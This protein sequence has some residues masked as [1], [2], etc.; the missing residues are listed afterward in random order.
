[1]ATYAFT[2]IHGNYELWKAIQSY[3][4]EDDTLFFLGDALDRGKDGIKIM[5][6]MFNDKRVIYIIGNHENM[7]LDFTEDLNKSLREDWEFILHNGCFDSLKKFNE[8]SKEEQESLRENLKDNTYLKYTYTNKKGQ[9]IFLSHAGVSFN[10]LFYAITKDLLTDREHIKEKVS[11]IP[12][13]LKDYVIVHG[14]TPVQ[15]I[16]GMSINP[17]IYYYCDS[18][19]IDLDIATFTTHKIALL[20]LDTLEPIYFEGKERMFYGC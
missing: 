19:K 18:K 11:L 20:D 7:F 15:F 12:E 5:Q 14:H 8:L 3:I 16:K 6:E 9:K 1:M 4:K 10:K 13:S 2:D 17:E